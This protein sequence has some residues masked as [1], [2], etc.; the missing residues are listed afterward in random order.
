MVN[1][2]RTFLLSNLIYS[3]ESKRSIDVLWPLSQRIEHRVFKQLLKLAPGLHERIF[4][5]TDE[6]LLDIADLVC[7]KSSESSTSADSF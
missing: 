5:G 3:S 4:T 7:G 6:D 2:K 1:R